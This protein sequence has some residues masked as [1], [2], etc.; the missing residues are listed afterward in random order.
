[1]YRVWKSMFSCPKFFETLSDSLKKQE[2][3][4]SCARCTHST[5]LQDDCED[6][7]EESLELY[8]H[9]S[10]KS[11]KICTIQSFWLFKNS[12]FSCFSNNRHIHESSFFFSE[13]DKFV[14]EFV[15]ISKRIVE[16]VIEEVSGALVAACPSFLKQCPPASTIS[17]DDA[18]LRE[19]L[20]Q[21]HN[22]LLLFLRLIRCIDW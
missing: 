8:Y 1:M 3:S 2:I 16:Q 4:Q 10:T 14:T 18:N 21:K 13:S 6:W 15:K 11:A 19:Q 12:L 7:M 9:I 17:T 5:K 20:C 22:I